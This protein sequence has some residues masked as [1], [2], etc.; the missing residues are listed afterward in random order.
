MIELRTLGTTD[1]RLRDGPPI[2]AILRQPKRLALLVYL[3][4]AAPGRFQRRDTLLAL[5][6]PELDQDHARSSLRRSLSF[7]RKALPEPLILTRGEDEVM[8]DQ[9]LL[10]LD[11]LEFERRL[12]EPSAALQLYQGDFLAGFYVSGAP[13]AEQWLDGERRRL[14][15]RALDSA[16]TVAASAAERN[17]RVRVVRFAVSLAPDDE[18]T[19]RRGI[20][21]LEHAGARS[22]ALLIGEEYV[23]RLALL[24][25]LEPGQE[26]SATLAALKAA[27]EPERPAPSTAGLVA[28]LPF[29]VHGN[30]DLTF[31]VEGMV[32]LVSTALDGAGTIRVVDPRTLLAQVR[33]AEGLDPARALTLVRRF[34]AERFVLGSIVAAGG[35]L[36]ATATLYD[37]TLAP[38][39]RAD[40]KRV[41]E[42]E[43]FE[44][45]DDLVRQ[46][47]GGAD[48]TP[49]GRLTHLAAVTTASVP[50][51]KHYLSGEGAL[52]LGRYLEAIGA[53]QQAI[54]VD[55]AFALAHFRLA[56][57]LAA[58]VMI[59]PA[60]ES[61]ERAW[62]HRA[63]LSERDHRLVAAY[64]AWLFGRTAEAER[65]VA[66]LVSLHP[67]DV[68]G[69][70]L[71]GDLL[72]HSNPLRGLSATEARSAFAQALT[73]DPEHMGALSHLI[74]IA[75]MAGTP[76]EVTHLVRRAASLS[77]TGDQWL[78]LQALA[79]WLDG[80][81][82]DR[83]AVLDQ[84]PL[85]R[86][87]AAGTAFA[88]LSVQARDLAGAEV[89]LA[90]CLAAARSE[91]LRA[92]YRILGAPVAFAR[93]RRAS[94]LAALA[95]G[96][97]V[98]PD[99]A[100]MV[101]AALLATAE[102]PCP[103]VQLDA[104]HQELL[105]W[106][107]GRAREPSLPLPIHDGL[108]GHIRV[109]LL[110]LI[111]SA[112]GLPDAAAKRAEEL[113]ELDVPAGAEIL[114]ERLGRV[115]EAV[116]LR[117]QGRTGEAL[118]V[119][120]GA[121]TEV[122]FQLAI[123]SPFFAGGYERLLRADLL[124]ALGRDQEAAPWLRTIAERSP[125]E[126][127]YRAGAERRLAEIALRGGD[128]RGAEVHQAELARILAEADPPS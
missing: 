81:D 42:S 20:Q 68:E 31:L 78:G 83:L 111:E 5:F 99:S 89:F 23:R 75:A 59:A 12:P 36:Q 3:A 52:R 114:I 21:L 1:L 90:H 104:L 119:L 94:A 69:W 127:P 101:R 29:A 108:Y 35:R 128:I 110:G 77:P 8:V 44:L 85:A 25:D 53:L 113:A 64:R 121:T 96:A 62:L 39:I 118:S 2:D 107:S 63:R 71:L 98:D 56:G 13:D 27:A 17:E 105:A 91:S 57:A 51:L 102:P 74:R 11:A 116:A 93:G 79:A 76:A 70:F 41:G 109:H 87:L 28:V 15:L 117:S 73:L 32:D 30:A 6:W 50:A 88:D 54:A 37:S 65:Q 112:L 115:L 100:L 43:L 60:R 24:D 92:M 18:P 58:N 61:I 55:E 106:D 82:S 123:A 49:A 26:L 14:R 9:S 66:T 124:I 80:T 86:V 19:V 22:E 38:L 16:W 67:E 72:F 126:T 46:L 125:F 34:G 84:I 95:E 97:A 4:L 40:A 7:L 122:W 10:W 103:A 120:E 33:S 45:V 47:V 48:R